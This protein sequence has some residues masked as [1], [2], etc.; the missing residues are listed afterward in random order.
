MPA[1]RY[2]LPNAYTTGILDFLTSFAAQRKAKDEAEK[3]LQAQA[4]AQENQAWAGAASNVAGGV[5]GGLVGTKAPGDLTDIQRFQLASSFVPSMGRTTGVLGQISGDQAA[6]VRQQAAFDQQRAM[7]TLRT[8]ENL[9][10]LGAELHVQKFGELPPATRA[11]FETRFGPGAMDIQGGGQQAPAMEAPGGGQ[12]GPPAPD[13]VPA[14]VINPAITPQYR[15]AQNL[16]SSYDA[17]MSRPNIPPMERA[18]IE[19]QYGPRVAQA[20][21]IVQRMSPPAPPTDYKGLKGL[22]VLQGGV[23]E[24]PFGLLHPKGTTLSA[25]S[26]SFA[27]EGIDPKSWLTLPPDEAEAAKKAHR[28]TFTDVDEEGNI[29]KFTKDGEWEIEKEVGEG[30]DLLSKVIE[31]GYKPNTAG[32]VPFA[33]PEVRRNAMRGLA[34]IGIYPDDIEADISRLDKALADGTLSLPDVQNFMLKVGTAYTDKD[35]PEPPDTVKPILMRYLQATAGQAPPPLPSEKSMPKSEKMRRERLGLPTAE[36]A[37]RQ[38]EQTEKQRAQAAEE[39]EAERLQWE[40]YAAYNT[41]GRGE[42]RNE[43]VVID[44]SGNF[45]RLPRSEDL[46]TQIKTLVASGYRIP[47]LDGQTEGVARRSTKFESEENERF[48]RTMK[49]STTRG[50]P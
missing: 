38:Q 8:D 18:A 37:V 21:Q 41:D 45:E 47:G 14:P 20:R 15:E 31:Q 39:I 6:V 16:I 28:R 10:Q 50:G 32:V 46:K 23:T 7:E 35:N 3:G 19:A 17:M 2:Y 13:A 36:S 29:W 5:I 4:S 27:P 1:P 11:A 33:K 22:G 48:L 12:M 24:T 49:K 42:V 9:R 43:L 34:E 26:K 44:A 25:G 40:S 30:R